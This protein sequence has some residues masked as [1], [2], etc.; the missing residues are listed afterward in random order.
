MKKKSKY[1]TSLLY[2]KE[3]K[4][5]SSEN[6]YLEKGIMK[7]FNENFLTYQLRQRKRQTNI[8]QSSTSANENLNREILC[9]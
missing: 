4:V 3:F 9:W 2:E 8:V 6:A 5:Y 1:Y 7:I